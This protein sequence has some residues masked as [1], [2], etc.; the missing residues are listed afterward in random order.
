MPYQL[1]ALYQH[2]EDVTVFDTH[3]DGTHAPLAA[4]MPG[5]RSYTTS[6]PGPDAGGDQPPYH[7][8]AVLTWADEAAFQEAAASPEF[9]AAVDD[10]ANFAGAGV[11][12]LTGPADQVV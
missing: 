4:K 8:A 6:R 5:L 2:P 12:I 9:K 7:L 1:I 11:A 10:L 3:Y